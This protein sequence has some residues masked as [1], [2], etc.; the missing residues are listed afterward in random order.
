MTLDDIA[1]A[2][3]FTLIQ[4]GSRASTVYRFV[5][6]AHVNDQEGYLKVEFSRAGHGHLNVEWKGFKVPWRA[7]FHASDGF[8]SPAHNSREA[9]ADKILALVTEKEAIRRLGIVIREEIDAADRLLREATDRRTKLLDAV[10]SCY[11]DTAIATHADV[12]AYRQADL[13]GRIQDGSPAGA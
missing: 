3:G 12:I 5:K 8:Y 1:K 10:P 13:P 4:K 7:S 11:R 2:H 9:Y 6:K